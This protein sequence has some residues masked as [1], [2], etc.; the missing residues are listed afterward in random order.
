[1]TFRRKEIIGACTLYLGDCREIVPHLNKVD[2]IVTD[3]P[4][5]MGKLLRAGGKAQWSVTLTK[6]TAWDDEPADLKTLLCLNK[7]MIVW[8]GQFF[9]LPRQRGWLVW[10]KLMS[11]FTTSVCELAW[12]N[13]DFP[14][15][16]LNYGSAMVQQE[17][18]VHPTQKPVALMQW[19]L[20]FVP[21]AEITL[22]PYMGSGTTGVACAK[23]GRSFVGVEI[24]ESYFDIACRRIEDAYR[25]AD[26]FSAPVPAVPQSEQFGL[27]LDATPI[28]SWENCGPDSN[29]EDAAE[30]DM[31]CWED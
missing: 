7:P 8:G 14:V 11:E 17:G 9:E 19:C 24:D 26:M 25:Q 2:A 27:G 31:D 30:A 10:D 23:R 20:G 1:M 3:P 15:K 29:P 13:L 12:T 5:G 16:R 28:K 4:Y 21:S 22:D 6:G 18:R